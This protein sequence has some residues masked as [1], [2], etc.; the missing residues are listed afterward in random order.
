[1]NPDSLIYY[2]TAPNVFLE[3][4]EQMT[5]FLNLNNGY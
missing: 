3:F 4:Q 2:L 1:M 5:G